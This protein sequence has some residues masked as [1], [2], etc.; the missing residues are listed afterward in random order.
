MEPGIAWATYWRVSGIY[1]IE[2]TINDAWAGGGSTGV[3]DYN[4]AYSVACRAAQAKGCN[5][6][7]FCPRE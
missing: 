5:L 7:R 2:L 1:C 6:E 3:R 4:E